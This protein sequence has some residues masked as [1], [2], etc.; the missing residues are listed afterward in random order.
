MENVHLGFKDMI[1]LLESIRIL[2]ELIRLCLYMF[3]LDQCINHEY[4][5]SQ[6][7]EK[8]QRWFWTISNSRSSSYD[9]KACLFRILN[10]TWRP[11]MEYK[12]WYFD[13]YDIWSKWLLE[14]A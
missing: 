7:L 13:R 9:Q 8:E 11:S 2:L 10:L 14:N 4:K 1:I 6:K 3:K 5:N 12:K